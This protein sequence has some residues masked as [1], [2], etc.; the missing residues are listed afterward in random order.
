MAAHH[1]RIRNQN[2]NDEFDKYPNRM[3]LFPN[4]LH[5]SPQDKRYTN[6]ITASL[7]KPI[8]AHTNRHSAD[9]RIFYVPLKRAPRTHNPTLNLPNNL[10]T[11]YSYGCSARAKATYETCMH[12]VI[13]G[14][15]GFNR[16]Q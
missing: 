2:R 10:R 14:F 4:L 7:I 12:N 6:S 9:A 16:F 15:E 8:L 11:V 5:N 13:S 1:K 3:D